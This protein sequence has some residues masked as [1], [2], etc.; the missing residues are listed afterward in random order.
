MKPSF[1][2]ILTC[3]ILVGLLSTCS[4]PVLNYDGSGI[5]NNTDVTNDIAEVSWQNAYAD[6]LR[7]PTNYSEDDHFAVGFALADLNDDSTPELIIGYVNGVEGGY[8]FANIY[9]FDGNVRVI[10]RQVD[11]YYKECWSSTNPLFPGL[12]VEGGRSSTF[13]CNYWSVDNNEFIDESLWTYA[14]SPDAGIVDMEFTEISNNEQLIAE[15]KRLSPFFPDSGTGNRKDTV[16]FLEINEVNI[17][18]F[19]GGLG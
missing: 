15:S 6:F 13:S 4:R 8:I 19:I 12:F 18:E 2:I 7:E 10:G 9:L 11:M 3:L 17:Q 5:D 1:L 16:E 14:V